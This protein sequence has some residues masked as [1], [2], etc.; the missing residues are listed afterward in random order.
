MKLPLFFLTVAGLFLAAC[1][2]GNPSSNFQCGDGVIQEGEECE[3]PGEGACSQYCVRD[4]S[5]CGDGLCEA[6]E[7]LANCAVDCE[8]QTFCGDGTRDMGEDCDGTDLNGATCESIGLG[9]GTLTCAGDCTF[10]TSDCEAPAYCGNNTVDGDEACDTMDL[11]GQSCQTLGFSGGTLRCTAACTLDTASCIDANCGNETMEGAEECDGADFGGASCSSVGTFNNGTLKCNADCTLDGSGCGFCANNIIEGTEECDGA[12]LGG[13]T[14]GSVGYSGGTLGC[15]ADCTLDT[16][17]CSVC[18]NGT[19]EDGEECDGSSLGGATCSTLGYQGGTL[20]CGATCRYNTSACYNV[21]CGD[22]D[23]TGTE[24]CDGSNLGGATCAS[25]GYVGGSLACTSGCS[26][27]VAGCSM[28]GD[29]SVDSG[30]QCDGADFNGQT[31]VTEGFDAGSLACN[32]N[33]TL[34]Y[35]GCSTFTCGDGSVNGADECDGSNLDGE[36]CTTLGYTGGTL[37]CSSSCTFNTASC[38]VCGNGVIDSGE[39]CDDGNTA[40]ND[41]CSASCQVEDNFYLPVRLVGGEGTNEGRLEVYF[42]GDWEQV[43]DDIYTTAQQH[44]LA[45]LLCTQLGYTGTGH[46]FTSSYADSGNDVFLMD[47]VQ[48]TGTETNLAQCPFKGWWQENCSSYETVG[49]ACAPADG[50]VRLVN[51]PSGMEGKMEVYHDGTWADV[52]DD[53]IWYTTNDYGTRVFC[54]QMGYKYGGFLQY[55]YTG[56]GTFHLDNVSCAGTEARLADCSH[57]D[58][59][60]HD[61]SASEASGA[62]CEVWQEGDIRMVGGPGLNEGRVEILHNNVWGSICDDGMES[63]ATDG[64]NFTSVACTELGFNTTGSIDAYPSNYPGTDPIWLDEVSCTGSEATV[65]VCP[66]DAWGEHDCSHNEDTV[67]VCTP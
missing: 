16:S 13:K 29:G 40:T 52:C 12:N 3:P 27:N 5:K 18:G 46:T 25:L 48:C 63:G 65:S 24:Q 7:S 11:Q 60:D 22:G 66:A 56:T 20:A 28:C 31:C 44:A 35:T 59:G 6:P 21:V 62:W 32:A 42:E 49:I 15:R 8:N 47:D 26:F 38:S 43:C 39:E 37:S 1:A 64:V 41:G 36:T 9:S 58:W 67:L 53:V 57:N 30:E 17:G 2:G 50:D 14:C 23:I 54:N 4:P 55:T 51:G 61:C 33:C 34:N 10:D 45:N 19:A